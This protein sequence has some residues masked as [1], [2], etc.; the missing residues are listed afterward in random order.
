MWVDEFFFFFG[1]NDEFWHE[2]HDIVIKNIKST[3]IWYGLKS[4]P[5]NCWTIDY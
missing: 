3:T 4:G 5:L 1:S 2:E